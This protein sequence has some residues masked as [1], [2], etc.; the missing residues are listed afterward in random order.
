N[1]NEDVSGSIK[2]AII[3]DAVLE[4]ETTHHRESGPTQIEPFEVPGLGRDGPR[5]RLL[6]FTVAIPIAAGV[7]T[8][9]NRDVCAERNCL[10]SRREQSAGKNSDSSTITKHFSHAD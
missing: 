9:R 8:I 2:M 5:L 3:G 7:K 6:V 10:T 4:I 1:I